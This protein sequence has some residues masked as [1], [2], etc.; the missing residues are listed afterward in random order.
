MASFT[1][2]SHGNKTCGNLHALMLHQFFLHN[3]LT[4]VQDATLHI[5]FTLKQNNTYS[6]N[7]LT[8]S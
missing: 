8:V 6:R 5:F 4:V 3:S 7:S 2:P 1:N